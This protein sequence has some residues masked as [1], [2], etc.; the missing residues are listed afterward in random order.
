M[1]LLSDVHDAVFSL[2]L[3]S[4]NS[5]SFASPKDNPSP[6]HGFLVLSNRLSVVFS[7]IILATLLLKSEITYFYDRHACLCV[8]AMVEM[9][10]EGWEDDD[11]SFLA[12]IF[13]ANYKVLCNC[14]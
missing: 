11:I 9:S 6:Y 4:Y 14:G 5:F 10:G 12:R 3:I 13:K 1:R 7:S 2:F 8:R